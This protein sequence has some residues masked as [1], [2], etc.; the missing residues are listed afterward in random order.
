[1]SA[2]G[3]IILFFSF[4]LILG[5][6][7]A[8]TLEQRKENLETLLQSAK[9]RYIQSREGVDNLDRQLGV[10][11]VQRDADGVIQLVGI[12]ENGFPVF[13]ATDNAGAAITTGVDKLRSGGG[14]GLN[15]LGDG[16]RVTIWDGG[17]VSDHIEFAG[18]IQSNEGS[19]DDNHATHVLGTIGA[20]GVNPAARGMAPTALLSAWDFDND[21]A[22][23]ISQARPDASGTI[24]SITLTIRCQV[25][26]LIIINGLGLAMRL[27]V[28]R[29]IG[30]LDFTASQQE[31]GMN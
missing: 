23:M 24:L 12:D 10:P 2:E 17:K 22:E 15:L 5:Q 1:M 29:K 30:S 8:Q 19:I 4:F 31:V 21:L 14:L 11:L 20:E 16:I 3:R 26:G 6:V 25:G 13:L 28:R 18:R 27:S 7:L 9:V